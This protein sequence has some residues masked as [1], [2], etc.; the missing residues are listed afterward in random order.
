LKKWLQAEPDSTVLLNYLAN[1]CDLERDYDEAESY[2]FAV[3]KRD[4][5]DV[6]ALNNA[7]FLES[8]HRRK[9]PEGFDLINRAIRVVG[10]LAELLDTRAAT[11]LAMNDTQ[12]A[13]R[14]LNDALSE[15]PQASTYIRLAQ[16]HM[17][18]NNRR[19][20]RDALLKARS[21]GV[22]A[23]N[24]HAFDFASYKSLSQQLK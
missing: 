22:E 18:A 6:V 20:A 24:L 4:P 16:A 8:I 23:T 17:S 5:Q 12:R 1:L 14:D 10:P 2:Y 15:K 13:I 11:Y 21:C 9:G 19:A 3:L 7:A